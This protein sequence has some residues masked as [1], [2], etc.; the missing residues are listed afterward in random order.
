MPT[1]K[2]ISIIVAAGHVY[3][4]MHQRQKKEVPF[5]MAVGNEKLMQECFP[6]HSLTE[7]ARMK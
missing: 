6:K 2:T 1:S 3:F 4:L 7:T 5:S